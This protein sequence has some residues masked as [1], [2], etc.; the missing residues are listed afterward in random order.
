MYDIGIFYIFDLKIDVISKSIPGELYC[1]SSEPAK[2]EYI[3]C[4]NIKFF[5]RLNQGRQMQNF[6]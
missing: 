4:F 3:L 5:V 1:L 2:N 6:V